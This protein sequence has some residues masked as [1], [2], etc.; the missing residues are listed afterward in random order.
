VVF[1]CT[2]LN[3]GWTLQRLL[4]SLL[5]LL[6]LLEIGIRLAASHT[7]HGR[8]YQTGLSECQLDCFLWS[9]LLICV[10]LK[11]P[12]CKLFRLKIGKQWINWYGRLVEIVLSLP[13]VLHL[14]P[15]EYWI[16]WNYLCFLWFSSLA[17]THLHIFILEKWR[18]LLLNVDACVYK[19]LK[20]GLL[21][22]GKNSLSV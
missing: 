1:S 13:P 4:P 6:K 3:I 8:H 22:L 10:R 7:W 18:N 20:H 11:I 16:I 2:N 19:P 5:C 15:V 9:I 12:Q 17:E 21:S 14:R